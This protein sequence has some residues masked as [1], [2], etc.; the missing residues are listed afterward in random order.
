MP[1]IATPPDVPADLADILDRACIALAE[2][3]AQAA[4]PFRFLTLATAGQAGSTMRTMV[5]RR[6][7]KPRFTTPHFT[8]QG[9]ELD[10]HTDARSPKLADLARMPR[11]GV[12]GWDPAARVQIRIA[13]H[14]SCLDATA[15]RD[16]WQTLPAATRSTYA[17]NAAPGTPI[18]APDQAARTLDPAASQA[19]F[20]VIR[21]R[22][23]ELEWL[24]L[25]TNPHQR[26]RFTF[27]NGTVHATWV[28]P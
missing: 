16:I 15:C 1:S 9:P 6:F 14:A 12:H 5:L 25:A 10:F 3:V 13:A 22:V 11:V 24:C 27:A 4:S 23:E 18:T 21:V 7:T 19:V 28:V 8:K 17:I 26:A 2:G 20:R